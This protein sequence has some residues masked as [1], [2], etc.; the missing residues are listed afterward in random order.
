[1]NTQRGMQILSKVY[2][3]FRTIDWKNRRTQAVAAGVVI[4]LGAAI[5]TFVYFTSEPE[6]AAVVQLRPVELVEV[7]GFIRQGEVKTTESGDRVIVVRAEVGGKITRVAQKEARVS[8]GQ[9]VAELENSSQRAA[10]LQAEGSLDSANAGLSKIRRGGREEQQSI[11]GTNVSSA[12]SNLATAKESAVSSL[13]SAYAAVEDAIHRKSDPLFDG[14]DTNVPNFS[15]PTTETQLAT[16]AESVRITLGSV[17]KRQSER[18]DALSSADDLFAEIKRTDAELR[19][20][21]SYLDTLIVVVNKAIPTSGITA[22]DIATFKV[23]LNTARSSISTAIANLTTARETLTAREAAVDVAQQNLEQGATADEADVLSASASVKQAQGAYA[24][25]L[26]AYQKT[27]I[28]APASGTIIAC[29]PSTG[30]VISTGAD[31]CRITASGATSGTSFAL[32]LSAVKYTPAGAYVFTVKED[33][34]LEMKSVET[35]LVSADSITV[36]GLIGDERIVHD[37]RGL[38]EGEKVQVVSK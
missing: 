3:M 8:L 20:V 23:D 2:T 37:V 25:A 24:S 29:S 16:Q 22:T 28:R 26:A 14:P 38:R 7:S 35:G 34:T 9:I 21:R 4:V 31:V 17:L 30:D 15:V 27:I 11:L 5:G 1:M 33:G 12:E 19:S 36:A 10:L 32:P 6:G 18:S 13:N